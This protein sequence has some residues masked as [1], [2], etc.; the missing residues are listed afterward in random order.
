[1]KQRLI[2]TALLLAASPVM[3]GQADYFNIHN[4]PNTQLNMGTWSI[5]MG[6]PSKTAT[7][8]IASANYDNAYN[9]TNLPNVTPTPENYPYKIKVDSRYPGATEFLFHLGSNNNATGNGLIAFAVLHTDVVA[10]GGPHELIYN[11]VE[12]QSHDGGFRACRDGQKNSQLTVQIADVTQLENARAGD[13]RAKLRIAGTGGESQTVTDSDN[14]RA[15]ITVSDIV[16]VSG[17][18]SEIDLGIHVPGQD[19][20]QSRNF[21][22]YAN[23]ATAA[24]SMTIS[25][26]NQVGSQFNL[27]GP[28]DPIPYDL[29]FKDEVGGDDGTKIGTV[30]IAGEGSNTSS[31]CGGGTNA[32][33]TI[34]IDDTAIVQSKSGDYSDTLMLLVAPN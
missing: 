12:S 9:S 26:D 22:V 32:K 11:A 24:Y 23:N 28:A 7:F 5:G 18:A 13:Y 21:C 34:R 14:F 33:L 29:Y 2:T 1:M 19:Q 20:I 16:R 17:L 25:S 27:K 4:V 15:D 31:T 30:S 8:C 6:P 10:G 3:A